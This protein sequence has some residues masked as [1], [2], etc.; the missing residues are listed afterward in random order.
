MNRPTSTP[1]TTDNKP[2]PSTQASPI[3]STTKDSGFFTP[4]ASP[5]SLQHT[6]QSPDST[7]TEE[8]LDSTVTF[9]PKHLP[10]AKMTT[11]EDLVQQMQDMTANFASLK[12]KLEDENRALS[13]RLINQSTPFNRTLPASNRSATKQQMN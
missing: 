2:P 9:N 13:D 1:K 10:L 8:T 6:F 5:Q 11:M 12:Q 4:F 3:F 7:L